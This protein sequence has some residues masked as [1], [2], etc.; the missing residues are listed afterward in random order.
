MKSRA[1][2][3]K[4][5]YGSHYTIFP[6]T[7]TQLHKWS[8]EEL[9]HKLLRNVQFYPVPFREV[10]CGGPSWIGWA[11]LDPSVRIDVNVMHEICWDVD[12]FI[13]K[14]TYSRPYVPSLIASS[15]QSAGAP[16]R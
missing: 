1:K 3:P 15:A 12:W 13:C 11:I 8:L 14:V 4:Y 10:I 9:S 16:D 5:S 7:G 2:I 6:V